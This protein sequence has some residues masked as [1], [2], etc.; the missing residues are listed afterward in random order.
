MRKLLISAIVLIAIMLSTYSYAQTTAQQS[1]TKTTTTQNQTI[2]NQ[3]PTSTGINLLFVL[4]AKTAILK[5]NRSGLYTLTF[6]GVNPY[7]TYYTNRPNRTQGLAA[8]ENFSGKSK[9][10]IEQDFFATI[11]TCNIATL[12]MEEAQS[13]INEAL[14]QKK[15]RYKY[16]INRNIGLGILKNELIETILSNKDLGEFCKRVKIQ[17][18]KNMVPV[19]P[20]RSYSRRKSRWRNYSMNRRSGL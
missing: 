14:E 15:L 13:E 12:L 18:Q 8:I 9:L 20:G 4:T 5:A 2:T 10:T 1:T 19:R 16:K 11:F 7:L 3:Q 6:I 17:M